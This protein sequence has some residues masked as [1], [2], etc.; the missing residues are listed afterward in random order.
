MAKNK[1]AANARDRRAAE[2]AA[3]GTTT[4]TPQQFFLNVDELRENLLPMID[5]FSLHL[6]AL[7]TK[8]NGVNKT[9]EI[10]VDL[11]EDRTDFV[12]L[13][14]LAEVSQAIS[15]KLDELEDGDSPYLLEVSSPGATRSLIERRHWKR[16][17]GRLINITDVQGEKFLARLHEVTDAGAVISRKKETKKGQKPSYKDPE[18]IKWST[19]SAAKV[20]IEFTN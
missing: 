15:A 8:G 17:I 18:T 19:I 5:Q 11:H 4:P 12:S 6:E 1:D 16:S 10:I 9:L 7:K 14:T 20:E 3:T 13:D 2:R